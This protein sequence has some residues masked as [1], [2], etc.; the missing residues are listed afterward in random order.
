MTEPQYGLYFQSLSPPLLPFLDAPL[1][2]QPFTSSSANF[3]KFFWLDA[4]WKYHMVSTVKCKDNRD[5]K[6]RFIWLIIGHVRIRSN[7]IHHTDDHQPKNGRIITPHCPTG[8]AQD[9][10]RSEW[11]RTLLKTTV[12]CSK[13]ISRLFQKKSFI[14]FIGWFA[15]HFAWPNEVQINFRSNQR[16][17]RWCYHHIHRFICPLFRILLNLGD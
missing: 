8:I 15:K 4:I 9:I 13:F 7:R 17:F 11:L 5:L 3:N 10:I 16:R 6:S 2:S 12:S 14:S 1:E